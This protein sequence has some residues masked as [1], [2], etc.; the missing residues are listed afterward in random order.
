[1]PVPSIRP[2]EIESRMASEIRRLSCTDSPTQGPDRSLKF[3]NGCYYTLEWG[4]VRIV[5]YWACRLIWDRGLKGFPEHPFPNPKSLVVF[6]NFFDGILQFHCTLPPE[7]RS[8]CLR[9]PTAV[10]PCPPFGLGTRRHC[11]SA[12]PG[13]T[14]SGMQGE[15]GRRF[16]LALCGYAHRVLG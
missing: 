6:K 16:F 4:L 15:V 12:G 5:C 11:P 9:F 10:P 13:G 8:D 7:F 2:L 1:M 3:F 14:Y